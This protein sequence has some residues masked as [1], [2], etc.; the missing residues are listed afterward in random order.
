M[1]GLQALVKN[2]DSISKVVS[3]YYSKPFQHKIY[4]LGKCNVQLSAPILSLI[5]ICM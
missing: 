1:S 5:H 4:F 3:N 2:K